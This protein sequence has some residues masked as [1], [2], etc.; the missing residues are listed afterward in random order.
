MHQGTTCFCTSW[1]RILHQCFGRLSGGHYG[2]QSGLQLR[3]VF[4]LDPPFRRVS[5]DQPRRQHVSELVLPLLDLDPA[6]AP[7]RAQ[8]IL[9]RALADPTDARE[10]RDRWSASV[11]LPHVAGDDQRDELVR[12]RQALV[13]DQA[14][15]RRGDKSP[16]IDRWDVG[17]GVSGHIDDRERRRPQVVWWPPSL[18]IGRLLRPSDVS[19]V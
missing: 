18:R 9:H 17:T 4:D 12:R 15:R 6:R 13:E 14:P 16:V 8:A 1:C 19:R 10:G 3:R 7:Q 5:P 2:Q 11:V